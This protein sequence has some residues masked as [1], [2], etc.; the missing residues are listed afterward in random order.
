MEI[1][2]GPDMGDRHQYKLAALDKTIAFP[3]EVGAKPGNDKITHR[4]A[5]GYTP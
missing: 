1:V 5:V 2:L 3:V 4:S